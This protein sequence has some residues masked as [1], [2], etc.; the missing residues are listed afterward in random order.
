MTPFFSFGGGFFHSRGVRFFPR[1]PFFPRRRPC[2]F[3]IIP[4]RFR[5]FPPPP[6]RF[7]GDFFRLSGVF[8]RISRKEPCS[9]A[10]VSAHL[11]P[12]CAKRAA[13]T[14][15]TVVMGKAPRGLFVDGFST[16]VAREGKAVFAM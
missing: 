2:P 14:P 16:R 6:R 15:G 3:L 9:F 10:T 4:A 8:P 11:R 12:S 5:P 1:P 13:D 7:P